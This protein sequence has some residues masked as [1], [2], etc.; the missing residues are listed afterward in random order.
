MVSVSVTVSAESINQF[1]FRFRY[2]AETKIVVSVVHYIK[3]VDLGFLV[4]P[5][6]VLPMSVINLWPMGP[7]ELIVKE[8]VFSFINRLCIKLELVQFK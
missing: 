7:H 5:A 4:I 1:G 3:G 8:R 2:R 6:I